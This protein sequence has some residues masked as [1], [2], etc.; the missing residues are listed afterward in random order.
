[1]PNFKTP[2]PI[3]ASIEI[4]WGEVTVRASDRDDTVVTVTPSDAANDVDVRAAEQ[5]RAEYAS[6]RLLVK[7]PKPRG[8]G[9]FAKPG[10][11]DVTIELPERSHVQGDLGA[12]A[13]RS[14]GRLGDC[15]VKTGAGDIEFDQA[16]SADL[17]T[18][19]GRIV[20][21]LVQGNAEITTGSGKL[22][23]REIDGNA[24]IKNSNGDI[25]VGG[26][27]G[28]L[29][30]NT[31]N[32]DITVD[33][34]AGDITGNTANGDI[35]I[36]AAVRGSATVKTGFGQI[37]VGIRSGTAARLD[38]HTGF[39]RVHNYMDASQ[40]PAATEETVEVHANTSYG[41]ILI[42]RS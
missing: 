40:A 15:R 4:A 27:T 23:V 28:S 18:G 22:R 32:G 38:V 30:V 6:G 36:G 26:V 5:T 37:E 10:S 41:D 9:I 31:A 34:A 21:D 35:R 14:A 1:M 20:V 12:G 29:R 42:R 33:H 39:G 16:K 2:E 13:F 19:A 3:S 11:I 17:T 8:F 24:V 25:W 7:G